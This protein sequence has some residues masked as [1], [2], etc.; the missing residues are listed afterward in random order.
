MREH[1]NL[2]AREPFHASQLFM[3]APQGFAAAFAGSARPGSRS[4]R[5]MVNAR[6]ART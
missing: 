4:K 2:A 1:V 5:G 6:S 3:S